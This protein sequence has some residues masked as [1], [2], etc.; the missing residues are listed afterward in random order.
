MATVA[1]EATTTSV[2]RK[3]IITTG[4]RQQMKKLFEE[5]K[6]TAD[7]C[8]IMDLGRSTVNSNLRAMG[9]HQRDW[10]PSV[11][12]VT[13][14]VRQGIIR[15]YHHGKTR[16]EI[17]T[18]F[19]IGR[20]TARNIEREYKLHTPRAYNKISDKKKSDM[21]RYYRLGWSY[22]KI[23]EAVGLSDKQVA[24]YISKQGL[25]NRNASRQDLKRLH[26][27]IQEFNQ[28]L[29]TAPL[30]LD[31][32]PDIR[33]EV[34]E[35]IKKEEPK[36]EHASTKLTVERIR[37]AVVNGEY[38]KYVL[39]NGKFDLEMFTSIITSAQTSEG[40]EVLKAMADEMNAAY[41]LLRKEV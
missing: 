3:T 23:G 41:E 31:G 17:M 12:K 22:E 34:K 18:M 36:M 8:E 39:V 29:I 14:E 26:N 2:R 28:A 38:G 33:E 24:A 25:C 13:P 5:G 37:K 7:I 4:M 15:A 19:S 30:R 6:S 10:G 32:T 9:I 27:A 11:A 20:S 21:C 1:S 35:P 40:I 16:Q